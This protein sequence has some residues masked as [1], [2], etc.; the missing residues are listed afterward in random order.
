MIGAGLQHISQHLNIVH[1]IKSLSLS[2]YFRVA[3][4][5]IMA[6]RPGPETFYLGRGYLW[7][8]EC[9][10]IYN[11]LANMPALEQIVDL[12]PPGGGKIFLHNI[13]KEKDDHKFLKLPEHTIVAGTTGVGKTRTLSLLASQ[14]IASGEAV[15]IVD[16]KG[17]RDFLN[18]VY[19]LAVNC[20]RHNDF[21]FFSLLH[22]NKSGTFDLFGDCVRPDE[23]ADRVQSVLATVGGAETSDPFVAF[24]WGLVHAVAKLQLII[25]KKVTPKSLYQSLVVNP[26]QIF[27]IGEA[28]LAKST[29]LPE[30]L[31][32]QEALDLYRVKVL[33]HSAEHKQKMTAVLIPTLT[34]M[35]TDETGDMVSPEV[36]HIQIK[37]IIDNSRIVY[38][39]LGS[40]AVSRASATMGKLFVQAIIGHIGKEYGY[41]HLLK[42]VHLFV[43]E[44]YS[45]AFPGFIEM[46]GKVRA[47]GVH[48]YLGMQSSS[49]IAAAL[50]PVGVEQVITNTS[51]YICHRIPERFF[52]ETISER[53]GQTSVPQK[54]VTRAI[55]AGMDKADNL[56]RS[57]TSERVQ[58]VEAPRVTPDM[59]TSLPVGEAFLISQGLTP[60]K[61][62][63]P[64]IEQKGDVED[65]FDII[66]P[67]R[68][69]TLGLLEGD[70]IELSL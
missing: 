63:I 36:A 54:V 56:F 67:E 32:L 11:Q 3:V 43:D 35:G 50:G 15:I 23:V 44:F 38:I 33:D 68:P 26:K 16:P 24:C 45:L 6:T 31:A 37:D 69:Y 64:L 49:D 53:F 17:D 52:S 48:L 46:L 27:S 18:S 42:G 62:V 34:I 47:A 13:G 55:A 19:R 57:S 14:L 61:L 29:S 7:G 30:R 70:N 20:G 51:N 22:P 60:I 28:E 41:N 2:N 25:R 66:N 4:D 39:S 12:E 65:F 10:Q 59:L 40:M 58:M 9:T 1:R 8:T 21:Q 5:W